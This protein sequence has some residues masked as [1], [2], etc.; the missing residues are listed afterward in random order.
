MYLTS[1]E[2]IRGRV[3]SFGNLRQHSRD[4]AP[5]NSAEAHSSTG[6]GSMPSIRKLVVAAGC[7]LMALTFAPSQGR[8]EILVDSGCIYWTQAYGCLE[9]QVCVYDTVYRDMDCCVYSAL[10]ATECTYYPYIVQY[11]ASAEPTRRRSSDGRDANRSIKA[12]ELLL[13]PEGAASTRPN[14]ALPG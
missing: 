11:I 13:R 9:Y 10:R 12:P 14:R 1:W 3:D 6:E 5:V 7:A 8:A 4:A 2:P